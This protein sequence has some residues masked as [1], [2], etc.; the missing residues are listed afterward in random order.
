MHHCD[1][2]NTVMQLFVVNKEVECA[3]FSVDMCHWRCLWYDCLLKNLFFWVTTVY[4]LPYRLC[5][6]ILKTPQTAPT[7]RT[8]HI[9]EMR[10]QIL[11][12][13][14]MTIHAH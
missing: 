13:K 10:L 4:H 14:S 2:S 9:A 5:I 7:G 8:R 12:D 3:V 1:M 6:D 11:L